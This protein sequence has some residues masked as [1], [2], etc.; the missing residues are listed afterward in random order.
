MKTTNR[1]FQKKR[2]QWAMIAF[3]GALAVTPIHSYAQTTTAAANKTTAIG[4]STIWG[5]VDGLAIEGL[6]QGPSAAISDLQVACVFEYTEGDIFISPPALPAALNGLV[7]LDEALHGT[8]TEIRKSGKFKGQSLETILLTPGQQGTLASKKLLLIGLGKRE[9]FN[10]ALMK[11]VAHVAMREALR[12]GVKDFSFASDLKDAGVDSPTALVAE[13]VVIGCI[14]AFRTQKWLA[15]KNLD[16][17]P[18]LNKIT[19]LAGPAFFETAG[20]GIKNAI[21]SLNN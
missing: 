9:D 8:L 14:D 2:F 5:K 15:E 10:P 18:V 16:Q 20:G 4:T 21:S 19:L 7:H 6:V 3:F 11:D 13:N 17:Q 1:F 12:L